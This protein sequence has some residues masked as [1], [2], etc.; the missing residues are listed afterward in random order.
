MV[1]SPGRFALV[2]FATA[3][4]GNGA[5]LRFRWARI[6]LLRRAARV[7]TLHQSGVLVAQEAEE[8][9]R[10]PQPTAAGRARSDDRG[11]LGRHLLVAAE[12]GDLRAVD[13]VPD[14]V[15]IQAVQTANRARLA[16]AGEQP[17]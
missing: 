6:R 16:V 9:R 4:A 11:T 2:V 5:L 12:P 17:D 15:V 14:V 10:V 1:R 8:L 7:P 3:R 13:V